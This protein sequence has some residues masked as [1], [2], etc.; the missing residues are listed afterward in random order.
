MTPT[1]GGFHRG[2]GGAGVILTGFKIPGNIGPYFHHEGCPPPCNEL[3]PFSCADL[4]ITTQ[5]SV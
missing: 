1:M 2:I 4:I 3:G 5:H